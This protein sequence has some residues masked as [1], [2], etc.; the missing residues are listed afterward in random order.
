[1]PHSV[2]SIASSRKKTKETIRVESL[3]PL[4]LRER[5]QALIGLLQDYYSHLNEKG[6]TSYALNNINVERDI[7]TADAEYLDLIQKEIAI[8]IPKNLLTD[9]VTL[10]KNLMRYYSLRGSTESIQLFFKILFN[11]NVEVYYP[12]DSM[13]IPSSGTWDTSYQSSAYIG[14]YDQTKYDAFQMRVANAGTLAI[15]EHLYGSTSHAETII[16]AVD[17]NVLTVDR[18]VNGNN[19][20]EKGE[21][22]LGETYA[23]LTNYISAEN[24]VGSNSGA[25][26]AIAAVDASND[27]FVDVSITSGAFN[28][29]D[30]L[31]GALSGTHR[32]INSI[33]HILT[34]GLNTLAVSDTIT[35]LVSGATGTI[36]AVNSNVLTV[37]YSSFNSKNAPTNGFFQIG[38]LI[39][40]TSGTSGNSRVVS[41]INTKQTVIVSNG[42][43]FTVG[44][45]VS[46][47]NSGARGTI[48][49][50][51]TNTLVLTNTSGAFR[52]GE[53]LLKDIDPSVYS[54]I[55]ATPTFAAY[56]TVDSFVTGDTVGNGTAYAT[57]ISVETNSITVG[58]ST[59]NF[60][61][62]NTIT[63]GTGIL[64]K[65]KATS[66]TNL[67]RLTLGNFTA[68]ENITAHGVTAKITRIDGA[69]IRLQKITGG[70]IAQY[71]LLTGSTS[72]TVRSINAL[73]AAVSTTITAIY[74]N[75]EYLFT[76]DL[77]PSNVGSTL[78]PGQ[79][80]TGA[81]SGA[82][83]TLV[84]YDGTANKMTLTNPSGN[85][86]R[87]ELV[88]GYGP[89]TRQYT[90]GSYT[91]NF[92]FL[93]DTIKV[94]DSYFYQK[95]SY[96]IRTGNNLDVWKNSFNRL[97]HPA[98]FIFFGEILLLIE[99]LNLKAMMPKD[100]P[101]L[102]Y[103]DLPVLIL[104][105][106]YTS[107]GGLNV[108]FIN[109]LATA[110]L[111]ASIT[112]MALD[113]PSGT[114]TSLMLK[115]FDANPGLM[116]DTM[117]IQQADGFSQESPVGSAYA[118][119]DHTI[120]E[121]INNQV[122]WNGVILGANL[123]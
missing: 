18:I 12:K 28:L 5:A 55:T 22:L 119:D 50:I 65:Q 86:T 121:V 88:S 103:D 43:L 107:G 53:N 80:V 79:I 49:S 63:G 76:L 1:M 6:Q 111:G 82:F 122:T 34:I 2:E 109:N 31:I 112:R 38:E 85:F 7:D 115:F 25:V 42:S 8:S 102:I 66:V 62:G 77:D 37:T 41:A 15:G 71:D 87:G 108:D 44:W 35:G 90:R 99:L 23:V 57:V 51:S 39:T 13:L 58:Y 72:A 26:G 100:Q 46:G 95:F 56:L 14:R 84:A 101:G 9:R 106:P 97:V 78:T 24:V 93:D 61:T 29:N 89:M 75:S 52:N 30:Y 21:T 67:Y 20:F 36:S 120:G 110:V 83:A 113:V 59:G 16:R 118:W 32:K 81:T 54:G 68:G 64:I 104:L 74:R 105:E 11:D 60:A 91:S 92:G 10:Y 116:Y 96:V 48:E 19:Q 94:Q 47:Q 117:T 40:A 114:D 70:S 123:I 69:N 45:V 17:G 4:E 3:I 33:D 27:T 73:T 98:G